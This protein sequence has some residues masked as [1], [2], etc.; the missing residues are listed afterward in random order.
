MVAGSWVWLWEGAFT[1]AP[2]SASDHLLPQVCLGTG[3][4]VSEAFK[5]SQVISLILVPFAPPCKPFPSGSWTELRPH[6][7]PPLL[8]FLLFLCLLP[9]SSPLPSSPIPL[10]PRP[11][12]SALLENAALAWINS[13]LD[14]GN[15]AAA[16]AR[17]KDTGL[18]TCSPPLMRETAP[19]KL[20]LP[21]EGSH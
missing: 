13:A 5:A 14:D 10:P 3:C 15:A 12:S 20:P 9:P 2:A 17:W 16:L 18:L 1:V 19:G 7:P 6:F 21:G 11:P 4:S 8:L